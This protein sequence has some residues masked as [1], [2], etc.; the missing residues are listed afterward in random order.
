MGQQPVIQTSFNSGEWAPTLYGRVDLTKYH[1]GAALL[2]NFFVDYRGGATTRPGTEY[3]LTAKTSGTTRLIPFQA[4]FSVGYILEFGANYIRFYFQGDPILENATSITAQSSGSPNVFTDAGH[5]YSNGDWVFIAGSYYIIANAAANTFTLTDLFGNA[6]NGAAPFTVPGTA[7]RVYTLATTYAAAEL[8]QIKFAQSVNQMI[9][10]H[11]NHAPAVLTLNTATNW[12]LA[13]ITFGSSVT[14]PGTLTHTSTAAGGGS[15]VA[16]VVTAVDA[17]GQ[18]SPP[19]API[20]L[21]SLALIGVNWTNTIGWAAVTGASS[22]NIYRTVISLTNTVPAGSDFGFVGNITGVSFIDTVITPNFS[23]AP[24]IVTNPFSGSGVQNITITNVGS[25]S[26]VAPTPT[27]SGGG[28][29]GTIAIATVTASAFSFNNQGSSYQP[30]D[31]LYFN[32]GIS[33]EV[34]TVGAPGSYIA[35]A[36]FLNHGAVNSGGAIGTVAVAPSS[37]TSVLG[38]GALF[39]FTWVL[40][41]IGL[42]APGTGYSTPPAIGGIS[43][44]GGA[45]TATLGAP[46]AGNPSV[47]GF[48]WERLIL[49]GPVGSPQQFNAS[50][51]GS[52]FN[53]D[54]SLQ[55]QAD[56][57]FQGTLVS[58]VLGS[59]KSMAPMPSGLLMFTDHGSWIING[60][61]PGSAATALDIV[62]NPQAYE[63][64][65]DLPPIVANY[66]VLYVQSKGSIVRDT[67]YDFYRNIFAGTDIS[68]LSSH[69]FYGFS[70]IDWA[71]SEEPYKLVWAT[72]NDG[73]LLSLTFLKE[74]E[75]IAW[76]HHVTQGTYQSVASVTEATPSGNVDAV[77]TVVRRMI[78]GTTVNYIERQ[79]QLTY[80]NDY[81][82]SWQVDAGIGYI[83]A[84]AT[85]FS[86][87]QH[88]GGAVVTGVADGV[89][90]NFTMPVSGTFVFG[91]GGT[92]GLT[93]IASASVVT[94]GLAFTPQLTTLPLDLGEPTVAGK[95]KKITGVTLK[96]VNALGLEHGSDDRD[97]GHA[98]RPRHREPRVD[99]ERDS[100]RPRHRR[101]AW[102]HRSPLGRAGTVYDLAKQS[103]SGDD[104][105]GRS[106]DS[107]GRHT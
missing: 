92:P 63:G 80:P 32:G 4:S 101:R 15:A 78:N 75:L 54:V 13:A 68:V 97:C 42:V 27:F 65:S 59:I 81:I 94:V 14:T 6:I 76:A 26:G 30:G 29:S 22:Y 8:F 86:G 58:G 31:I 73:T 56:D 77:Y 46:S 28:G 44:G 11:P 74:Q 47:P 87:A 37:S 62:A 106:R 72:R 49:A 40:S 103:L 25:Y 34:L 107:S 102:H 105:R 57:A 9:L 55:T 19:T 52:Y 18:E 84:A 95:R 79:V 50:Q 39:N 43:S 5:G 69:L 89:V 12:T 33:I 88:L 104:P 17:N 51:P 100:D 36:V 53:Y 20:T 70:L 21:S 38:H 60:G 48:D 82:S 1:S 91:P 93:G 85:T 2:Q 24:P 99:D 61:S 16:Y 64:A 35:S 67:A 96:V 7:Q 71:W 41:T 83:G 10:C 98:R 66:D 23:I 90:I 3:I 45:A